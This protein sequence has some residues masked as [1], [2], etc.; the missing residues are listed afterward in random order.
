MVTL[1]TGGNGFIGSYVLRELVKRGEK[2]VSYDLPYRPPPENVA[3]KVTFEKGDIRYVTRLFEV[4]KNHDV[5]HIIHTVSLLTAVSQMN[6]MLA[7]DI[8]GKGTLNVLEVA[9]TM[10]VDR[11][12]Y[13]SG[14]A[15]YGVTERDKWVTE[16]HPRNPVTIYGAIKVL[17][18]DLG[19]NY[20]KTYGLDFVAVRPPIAYGPERERGFLFIQD[21]I[22]HAVFKK[23]VKIPGGG[24]QKFGPAHVKDA[25]KGLVLASFKKGLK[26]RIFNVGPGISKMYTLRDVANM[27]KEFVPE[28]T[29]DIGPGEVIEDP[30]RGPLD[31]T[32][33]R[34]ELNYE[35]DYPRLEKGVKDFIETLIKEHAHSRREV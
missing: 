5:D 31:I 9:R 11:V 30:L 10:D 7:F 14:A 13:I 12:V 1:V 22:E 20:V 25:A 23:H 8:N 28:A 21:C 19:M 4:A 16:D 27:V 17:C 34:E 26:H 33:A 18:E 24:D 32:R 35:P 29:F 15:V 3:K 2:A 6:P